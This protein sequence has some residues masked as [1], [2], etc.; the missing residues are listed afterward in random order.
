MPLSLPASIAPSRKRDIASG[1]M[2]AL[3]AGT[4]ACFMTACIAGMTFILHAL[5]A[6]RT[7][8]FREAGFQA[9]CAAYAASES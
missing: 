9:A 8:A 5:G 1:A 7:E 2:R 3:I 6:H 4:I